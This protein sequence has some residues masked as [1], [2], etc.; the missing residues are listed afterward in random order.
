MPKQAASGCT[1]EVVDKFGYDLVQAGILAA[2]ENGS[3]NQIGTWPFVDI[4]ERQ[5]CIGAS[6]VACQ[7]HFS[8]F[9]Q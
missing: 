8:K 4:E 6:D 5:P 3:R 7:N 2:G 9:L 1:F